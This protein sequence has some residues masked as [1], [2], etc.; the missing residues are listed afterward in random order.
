MGIIKTIRLAT[1]ADSGV[2]LEIYAPYVRDTA[3]SFEYE[4]PSFADFR[5]RVIKV[6]ARYPWLV[7]EIDRKI[8]GYAYASRHHERAA[9]G[10]AV[11]ASVY[12]H[13]DYHR[14]KIGKAL[15]AALFELL[16]YQGFYNVY[17]GITS[18]NEKSLCFHETFG[19]KPVGVYHNVGYKFGQWHDVTWMELTF[20]EHPAV[21]EIPKTLAEIKDTPQFEAIISK[22]LQMIPDE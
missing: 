8:V 6:L 1:E 16:K 5:E 10:W 18:A 7:C 21:P 3:I 20:A 9:Y 12:I 15:Y 11:D 14:K 19:F 17:A 13:A 4:V 2:L 22:A